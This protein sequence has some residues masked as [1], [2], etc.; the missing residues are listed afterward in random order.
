[1]YGPGGA[2]AA[3]VKLTLLTTHFSSDEK[4]EDNSDRGS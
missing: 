1:M 4:C 3:S 2:L